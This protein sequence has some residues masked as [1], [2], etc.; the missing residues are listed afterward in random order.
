LALNATPRPVT[1]APGGVPLKPF[2]QSNQGVVPQ[3][4]NGGAWRVYAPGQLPQGRA[5]TATEAVTLA[6]QPSAGER[7]YLRGDFIVRAMG[8]N[9]AVLRPSGV[10]AT[11]AGPVVRVI[12]EFPN[13]SVPPAE[14]TTVTRDA[15]RA[16]Q[17]LSVSRT[18]TGEVNIFVR[19]ITR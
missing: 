4:E 13:G 3:S 7:I 6:D 16:F 10:G 14:G 19:D 2:V 5:V 11:P 1:T 9:K 12:A 17:V 15:S 18:T 8:E